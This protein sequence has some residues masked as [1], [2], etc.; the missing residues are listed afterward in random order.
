MNAD[1]DR[2]PETIEL[3][4]E[5]DESLLEQE[6]GLHQRPRDYHMRKYCNFSIL[7]WLSNIVMAIVIAYLAFQLDAKRTLLGRFELAGDVNRISPR[8]KAVPFTLGRGSAHRELQLDTE[9]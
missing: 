2:Q 6:L 9:E 7:W 8:R 1:A 3:E 5:E 4:G